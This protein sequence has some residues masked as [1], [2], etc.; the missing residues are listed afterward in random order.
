[1]NRDGKKKKNIKS[2]QLLVVSAEKTLNNSNTELYH[3]FY[4][5]RM[6]QQK[7]HVLA[8]F[9]FIDSGVSSHAYS[10]TASK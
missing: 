5:F 9:L 10:N 8:H 6:G 2:F 4:C 1:M 3:T 7:P